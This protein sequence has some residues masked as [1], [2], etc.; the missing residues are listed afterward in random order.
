MSLGNAIDRLC[1]VAQ[2]GAIKHAHH[3]TLTA[4]F[5]RA[6]A[7]CAK[8]H[9]AL[10]SVQIIELLRTRRIIASASPESQKARS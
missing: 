7:F 9:V 2:T 5:L 4:G 6:F 1:R 3:N 10:L 8:F